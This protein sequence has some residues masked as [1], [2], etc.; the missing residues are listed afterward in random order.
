MQLRQLINDNPHAPSDIWFALGLCYYRVGNIPKA[1]LSFEKTLE[2]EPENAMALVSLGIVEQVTC[3]TNFESNK[4]S[5]DYFLRAFNSNPHNPLVLKY[6]A[7][8]LFFK[9]EYALSKDFCEAALSLLE[10]KIRPDSAELPNFRQEI[11]KL[12]SNFNF[13][14]GKTCHVQNDFQNAY[15]YYQQA[16][17]H[18]PHNYE[19]H[20]CMAKVQFNDG[21]YQGAELNLMT[22]LNC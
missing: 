18:N 11:E 16:I 22:V 17:K 13:T 5:I 21:N 12:K 20:L 15:K 6:L 8:H 19:A 1:R 2:L 3:P 4:K 14:L 10:T 7:E 9:G